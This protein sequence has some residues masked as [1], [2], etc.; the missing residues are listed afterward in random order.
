MR[1]TIERLRWLVLAAGVML[2]AALA[3]VFTVDKWKRPFN[4]RDLPKRLGVDIQ[5]EAN[6]FTYTQAHGGH[7]LFKIQA[8]RVEQLKQGNALLHE[9]H[10]EMY[11][12][13]G[14]RVDRIEGNE[15]EYNQ[16]AGTA[17][18]NGPVDITLTRPPTTTPAAQ[19]A[20]TAR[21]A[22]PD[23]IHVKTSGL[24]FDQNS[25]LASTNEAVEFVLKQGT[26]SASGATFDSE[27]GLLVLDRAVK[28]ELQR[29]AETV[30][31]VAN[32]GEF[33]RNEQTCRLTGSLVQDRG[34]QVEMAEATVHFRDDGSASQV[35][36]W[37]GLR[38]TS[39]AGSRL[40][41]PTGTLELDENNHPRSGVLRGG[42][43]V[44]SDAQGRKVQGSAPTMT[45]VFTPDG[46]LR[47]A[48]MERGVKMASDAESASASGEV[49][50]H[51]TWTSMVADLSFRDAGHGQ[52]ELA[53]MHGTGGVVVTDASR[54]GNGPVTPFRMAADEMTGTFGAGSTLTAMTG[55]GHASMEQTTATGARQT[56]NGDRLTAQFAQ[57]QPGA[58]GIAGKNRMGAM[59]S[60]QVESATVE[61]HVVLVQQ[62]APKAGEPAP[63]AMRATGDKAVYLGDGGKLRLT[64]D[65]R[66][67]DGGLQLSARMIDVAQSAGDAVAQG[68]VKAT[69]MGDA[70]QDAGRHG[71]QAGNEAAELGGQGPAHVVADGAELN[72]TTGEVVFHGHARL[73][74]MTNSISAPVIV[75]NRTKQTLV[76]RAGGAADPVRVV[77]VSAAGPAAGMTSGPAAA[78][79]AGPSVIRMRGGE[80]MYSAAE[81]KAVM[82]GGELGSVVAETADASSSSSELDVYLLPPGNHAGK[83]GAAAQVD[84]MT[85]RGRVELTEQGRHGTGEQLEYS[86]DTGEY[87]LTG[88]SE[89][90]PRLVDP[91]QGSV[92]GAVLIFNTHDDSVKVGSGGRR[93][94]TE[95]TAPQGQTRRHEG[96]R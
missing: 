66:V 50:S 62:A 75:L 45:L 51:E 25:G 77:M 76:A 69:W 34:N 78:K 18:A 48:H 39:A 68:D 58:K 96:P 95:T 89:R 6:G 82:R 47:Q 55:T 67:E 80:L 23:E 73:W 29:G 1:F 10:I 15:F 64:G 53:A 85:A 9:V 72:Q 52:L 59:G 65:P 4:R 24:V 54:R 63:A 2:I 26:G 81:R 92:T 71:G 36:A 35:E 3:V 49:K 31:L 87:V 38:V 94:V 33:E 86:S 11:G 93:T 40:A 28:L 57:L 5:Q 30:R 22:A 43:T 60:S 83:G 84:R 27:Q 79:P 32:H 16:Q 17:K 61:G 19:K 41:A 14:S 42:V 37:H 90:P 12:A 8:S 91:V 20:A 74:Q 88:T 13:D 46:V 70:Q 44:D 7:T 21:A 56:T